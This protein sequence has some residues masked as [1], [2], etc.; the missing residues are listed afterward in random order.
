MVG[1]GSL[2]G[3]DDEIKLSGTGQEYDNFKPNHNHELKAGN[4]YF[5][6]VKVIHDL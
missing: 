1:L 3:Q 6:T 4:P 2:S 5:V